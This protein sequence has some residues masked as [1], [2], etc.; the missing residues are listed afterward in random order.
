MNPNVQLNKFCI[1]VGELVNN[2]FLL[3]EMCVVSKGNVILFF[4]PF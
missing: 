3:S 4:S 1:L 2:L